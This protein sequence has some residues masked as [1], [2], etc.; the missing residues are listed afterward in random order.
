MSSEVAASPEEGLSKITGRKAS[1]RWFYSV[2]PAAAAAAPVGTLIQLYI[3][4]L[5]GSV[6]DVG[7]VTTLF[8]AVGI[9][10]AIIWGSVTDRFHRRKLIIALSAFALSADFILLLLVRTVFGVA[11]VYALFSLLSSASATPLN[12]LVMETQPKLRWASAFARLSMVSSVGNTL[13]FVLGSAWSQFLPLHLLTVPLALLTIASSALSLLLIREPSFIFEREMI[14][15]QKRS[16]FQRLLEFPLAFLR[17]PRVT[18]FKGVFKGLRYQ[19]TREL[20]VL[21]L[22]IFAFYVSSGLFNT[23]LAPSLIDA[24][25]T[26]SEVFLVYLAGMAVQ[27]LAFNFA[28]PYIERRSLRR[29]AVTGLLLRAAG[30]GALGIS[31]SLLTGLP[32]L[33][34]SLVFYPLAAGIAFAAYYTASNTMIFNTLGHRG[35]GSRLG[36]YSALV[37]GATTLGSILSG[38]VSFFLGF[39]VTFLLAAILLAGAAG[40][41]RTL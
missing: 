6:I 38:Y 18:D 2:L 21:Y 15:M 25:L 30:Y 28:G 27:T 35:Q 13:G 5:H 11:F 34:T 39:G 20:P 16:F 31:A 36:V 12:L 10:A 9:P 17:V 26:E 8:N 19:L 1:A 7:L 22:S 24:G 37:G 29:T 40:L 14:V 33:G 41:A 32:Y 4:E 23:S 3:I